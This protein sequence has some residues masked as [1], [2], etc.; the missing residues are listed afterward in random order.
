MK[1]EQKQKKL[2][3]PKIAIIKRVKSMEKNS[4]SKKDIDIDKT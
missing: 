2:A 4:L 1:V 3:C